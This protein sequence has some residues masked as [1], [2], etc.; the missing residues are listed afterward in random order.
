MQKTS[1][2]L[3]KGSSTEN[4]MHCN[5]KI[6]IKAE[7]GKQVDA[8]LNYLIDVPD[9]S[10]NLFL[11]RKS[12]ENEQKLGGRGNFVSVKKFFLKI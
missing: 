12:M 11:I 1:I 7:D 8:V 6:L 3:E 9:L 4:T 10:T 2:T 5:L